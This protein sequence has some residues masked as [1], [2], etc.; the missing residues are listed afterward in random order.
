MRKVI[1][2]QDKHATV[3]MTIPETVNDYYTL[4]PQELS[5]T[6]QITQAQVDEIYQNAVAFCIKRGITTDVN[7]NPL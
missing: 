7:G 3:I 4:F 6:P 2:K 1:I 5:K